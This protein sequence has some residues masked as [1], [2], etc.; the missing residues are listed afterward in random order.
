MLISAIAANRKFDSRT[1]DLDATLIAT[2]KSEALYCYK[3]Y[4]AFQPQNVWWAEQRMMLYTEFR[5]GNVPAQYGM[6]PVL[7]QALANLPQSDKP[8][9]LRS[10]SAAY[11]IDVMRFCVDKSIG[12][13]IGWSFELCPRVCN[14]LS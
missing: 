13:A 7:E 1:L 14:S 9:Y 10:D 8:I 2:H 5:D 3:K 11:Q 4:K 12:F 6:L